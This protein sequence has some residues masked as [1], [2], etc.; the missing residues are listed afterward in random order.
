[1]FNP[2]K[3]TCRESNAI[4][5]HVCTHVIASVCYFP[6]PQDEA[7]G[8]PSRCAFGVIRRDNQFLVWAADDRDGLDFNGSFPTRERAESH[9][10]LR[11]EEAWLEAESRLEGQKANV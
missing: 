4:A 9:A 7:L 5:Q 11:A 2:I 1:M 3:L 10:C 6:S 8:I